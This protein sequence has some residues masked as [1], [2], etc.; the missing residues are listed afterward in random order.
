MLFFL[1]SFLHSEN[2][3][4]LPLHPYNVEHMCPKYFTTLFEGSWESSRW[5]AHQNHLIKSNIFFFVS[6]NLS[7]VSRTFSEDV[8]C[9]YE[10]QEVSNT[11]L[12][13]FPRPQAFKEEVRNENQAKKIFDLGGIWTHDLQ[14]RS[15]S[16]Y[17][18]SYEAKLEAGWEW[19]YLVA[20]MFPAWPVGTATVI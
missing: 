13:Y 16:F 12:Y 10:C 14:I 17:L 5:N 15:P 2:S 18:L 11:A 20:A 6:S 3:H 8:K 19:R 9:M 7:S 1:V 4:V